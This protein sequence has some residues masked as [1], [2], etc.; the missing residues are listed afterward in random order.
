MN[1]DS[2][3]L[4]GKKQ[5]A[6][7]L[8]EHMGD[9]VACEPVA[10]YLRAENPDAHIV[11]VV[12]EEYRELIDTNPNIDE[13]LIVGCLT[14]WLLLARTSIF[15]EVFD[16]H[17]NG[18]VC[19]SCRIPLQKTRGNTDVAELTYFKY[20]SLLQAF[21][22]GAG[23]PA[24]NDAPKVYIPNSVVE[25][26]DAVALPDDYIVVHATS[27]E[28]VKD[29]ESSKWN[30]LAARVSQKYSIGVVE[31]GLKPVLRK[32]NG[33]SPIDLCGKL[34]IL[35]TA[36][37]IKRASLFIGIDSGPAH[38]GNA[39]GTFG[40][41]LLGK[42]KVYD[43]YNP[44]SGDYSN[45][46][47]AHLISSPNHVTDLTVSEVVS[48]FES[49][50]AHV[51]K[52]KAFKD[53]ATRFASDVR[54]AGLKA[55]GDGKVRARAIAFH[56]PQFHPIREN[57][58][59]WG[60]GF[61]EWK[62]VARAKP[63]YP[64]HRQPR[65]PSDL[66]F[67]DLRLT[68]SRSAQAELA[69]KYGIEGFCY[70]HYWFNGKLLLERPVEETIS[71]KEPSLPFCLAWANESWTRRWDGASKQILQLQSYGGDADDTNHFNWLARAFRDPR[72]ITVDGKPLFLI[73][74]P[75]D[76]PDPERTLGLWHRLAREEGLKGL[77][78]IAVRSIFEKKERK[79]RELG[80]DGELIHH[81]NFRNLFEIFNYRRNFIL[82]RKY[83]PP[84]FKREEKNYLFKFDY[85]EAVPFL[86]LHN[87]QYVNSDDVYPTVI[88]SW[89]NS[90]RVGKQSTLLSHPSPDAYE[91][92]L[93]LE[94]ERLSGRDPEHRLLFINAWNE[95]AEGMYLEP[96]QT[97][98][99][100]FLEA[101][102]NA[103]KG[104]V[105]EAASREG[106]SE[107]RD[108]VDLTDVTTIR[109][110]IAALLDEARVW[111]SMNDHAEA[112]PVYVKALAIISRAIGR[113]LHAGVST[114]SDNDKAMALSRKVEELKA[115]SAQLQGELG[116]L[117]V[118]RGDVEKAD[119]IFLEALKLSQREVVVSFETATTMMEKGFLQSSLYLFLNLHDRNP[120][121]TKILLALGFILAKMGMLDK[122]EEAYET[123]ILLD[124]S[125]KEAKDALRSLKTLKNAG[126]RTEESEDYNSDTNRDASELI[127]HVDGKFVYLKS[128]VTD[129][130]EGSSSANP[131]TNGVRQDL[132]TT[133]AFLKSLGPFYAH[134]GGAGDALLLLSTFY[135]GNPS[136]RV[137]SVTESPKALRSLF[138]AFPK[139]Q[140]VVFVPFPKTFQVHAAIRQLL[141]SLPECAGMGTT[142]GK[143]DYFTE[144]ADPLDIFHKYGVSTSPD[145]AKEFKPKKYA[146][147]QVVLQPVGGY[148]PLL[149]TKRKGL[150]PE[151][152]EQ[153]VS[154]LNENGIKPVV[155][156]TPEEET[157]YPCRG[158]VTDK[159]SHSFME[160]ME[161][162]SGGDLFVGADSWGKTFAA[163]LQR[164][165]LVLHSVGME[166]VNGHEEVGDNVFLKPWPSIK[167]AKDGS[168]LVKLVAE[169]TKTLHERANEDPTPLTGKL[170]IIWEG[171]QFVN[172]SMALINR[173]LTLQLIDKGHDLSI[174]PYEQD[175]YSHRI[176]KRFAKIVKRVNKQLAG[177]ADIHVRHQ[178]P[179]NLVPPSEGH[180]VVIQ[181]WEFGSIPKDWIRTMNESVDEVWVPSTYV[182]DCYVKSGL[183]PD[184][185]TVVPNG[186][187][188]ERFSPKSKP[189]Q[190]K[191]K[192]KFKFLFIGGTIAR[193]GIDILLN[194]YVKSFTRNDD[195][196]LV[197]KDMLGNSFYKGQTIE[198]DLK[199]ISSDQSLPEIEY[200]N[201]KLSEEE[202]AGLYTAADCLVHPYR[203][204]GFGLPIAE[205]LSS[206]LPVIVTNYGAALDFCNDG[207][208]YL[209][210][211]KVVYYEEK[212]IG[213][214]ETVDLPWLAEPDQT[215]VGELMR[216]IHESYEEAKAK[217]RRG[218][219]L[220]LEK[221]SWNRVGE[222][223]EQRMLELRSRPVKRFEKAVSS[224]IEA[225]YNLAQDLINAGDLRSAAN[226]LKEL[227]ESD[228]DNVEAAND[229]AVVYSMN[230]NLSDAE[231][232]LSDVVSRHPEHTLAK[233]NLASMYSNQG[234]FEEA[235]AL[236][237]DILKSTPFDVEVFN[238]LGQICLR[239]GN[240]A[241]A[242]EFFSI[243][244]EKD[245]GNQ[246]AKKFLDAIESLPEESAVK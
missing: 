103:L 209:I 132:N 34:S 66:G 42:Y 120:R 223:A 193:K 118:L 131:K 46:L 214:R 240:V 231:K 88:C 56:L 81:P 117:H 197:I 92:W 152:F 133:I 229:L 175:E 142:P 110:N 235:V 31:V 191:T 106:K 165:A 220:I 176:D 96:D 180:W 140:Q 101:T 79:W 244:L 222:L 10:R 5:I 163:L 215:A 104:R 139:L 7:G 86:K 200:V 67:Y 114:I 47:N 134:F 185:I 98:G 80:F 73:Y 230:G 82:E 169:W 105:A 158:N 102:R 77:Y 147:L 210:P 30:E 1:S 84:D 201:E 221:F 211:S 243:I 234:K 219:Q 233:K 189:Y 4:T 29:W 138:E 192:K 32:G 83:I 159:R 168:D 155:I 207:N 23:L 61:T 194:A 99:T 141:S 6:I 9:I 44:Y 22:I 212:K 113:L 149:K 121:D 124:K 85:E 11:W 204:E 227:L 217:A 49:C 241:Q 12:R 48:V 157:L 68:E 40:I 183:N 236:Y 184:G 69:K 64:G 170:A 125:N 186:V 28:A 162:I 148:S 238:S 135:D 112:G 198:E 91:K 43:K 15:D 225:Q 3:Q 71:T 195:V 89:D 130:F 13:T 188:P 76:L 144:W 20:G 239:L 161:I 2:K 203:G 41:I 129:I 178:W 206:E 16:L 126:R 109:V 160:Q 108:E 173:E 202:I 143:P 57:D 237:Q 95:W 70:W 90:P 172:H 136:A 17:I 164:P 97:F 78:V 100:R 146:K 205:A 153:V 19:P 25:K 228:G 75:A 26:V 150:S 24:L 18:R 218:R 179:P 35:E 156:G 62:N 196:C 93:S 14:E 171:S 216:H 59:W 63:L 72:Y 60:K 52:G 242:K 55:I 137:I 38:L 8:V 39:V 65:V 177:P 74:R 213:N 154:L 51:R 127:D 50:Y 226:V 33:C 119:L 182:R 58:E 246:Q 116:E 128:I 167:V 27:N 45:G 115:L 123:V 232:V 21:A 94:V 166:K 87:D 208:S 145:W 37:V 107:L 245:P 199:R 181:P 174:I 111:R 53:V 36:E 122:A 187:N 54:K 190:L 224:T 151:T